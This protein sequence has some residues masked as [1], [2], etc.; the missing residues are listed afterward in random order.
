[1]AS[2]APSLL[3]AHKTQH[4]G[5]ILGILTILALGVAVWSMQAA[6]SAYVH[7][8]QLNLLNNQ[9]NELVRSVVLLPVSGIGELREAVGLSS[10]F[11]AQLLSLSSSNLGQIDEEALA[12]L[13]LGGSQFADLADAVLAGGYTVIDLAAEMEQ[14]YANPEF[15]PHQPILDKIAAYFFLEVFGADRSQLSISH[16]GYQAFIYEVEAYIR[17]TPATD[18]R[19]LESMLKTLSPMVAR[20][21]QYQQTAG[22][23]MTHH[24]N[25]Q[26]PAYERDAAQHLQTMRTLQRGAW[27]TA[28][29][30][31]MSFMVV[32]RQSSTQTEKQVVVNKETQVDSPEPAKKA[33]PEVV[34]AVR[35]RKTDSLEIKEERQSDS[36]ATHRPD[37]KQ[38][39]VEETSELASDHHGFVD[40]ITRQA[41]DSVRQ[42]NIRQQQSDVVE[43]LD[44]SHEEVAEAAVATFDINYM[45]DAMD[46]DTESVNM[47]LGV[48]L[49]EH[50]EDG[51]R[52]YQLLAD[53]RMEEAE[54]LVHSIKGVAGSLGAVPLQT[55]AAE[56]EQ[57]I[58]RQTLDDEKIAE[59]VHQLKTLSAEIKLHLNVGAFSG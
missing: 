12:S 51:E 15:K 2:M 55:V 16:S 3:R 50:S 20:H 35:Q 31:V 23:V 4:I 21:S 39:P 52:L 53:H 44:V 14:L 56:L 28:F 17:Q 10:E 26:L 48:F 38:N 34:V 8:Q 7:S 37:L 27:M 30:L 49:E 42:N 19:H 57:C 54:R 6:N 22:E 5:H 40:V 47:L 46:D 13:K 33:H 59:F 58:K 9:R 41:K 1:M 43:A 32:M 24:F 36:I 11:R 29:L 18:R 25:R 45:L